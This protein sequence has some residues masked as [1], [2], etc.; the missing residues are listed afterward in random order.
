MLFTVVNASSTTTKGR[1]TKVE[2]K[3]FVSCWD[4]GDDGGGGGGGD[5]A[6]RDGAEPWKLVRTRQVASK[7]VTTF[8]VSRTG[9]LLAFGAA[10]LSVGILAARGASLAL[11]MRVNKA[12]E[13][14]CTSLAF[15]PAQDD[16]D[17]DGGEQ[18]L[19]SASADNSVR[20]T[21][22][23]SAIQAS[24]ARSTSLLDMPLGLD[25]VAG[26]LLA[27]VSSLILFSDAL[28]PTSSFTMSLVRWGLTI[29][30]AC[31]SAILGSLFML[32]RVAPADST[33]VSVICAMLVALV[34]ASI[35]QLIMV[36]DDH[37]TQ[38]ATEHIHF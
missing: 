24:A 8:C 23:S 6:A 9:D 31:A 26:A 37:V 7:P 35:A 17:D 12:H 32:G 22:I 16:E 19:V 29:L 36:D 10:D 4:T 5:G 38:L 27:L 30:L 11:L 21:R 1:R 25:G 34:A 14:P 3:A 20:V 2:R 13:F 15:I 18:A 28:P 33:R